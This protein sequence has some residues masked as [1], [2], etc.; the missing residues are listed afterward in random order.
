[1]YS[2]TKINRAEAEDIEHLGAKRKYW[3]T[4]DGE[5]FLFKAEERGTGEDWAEKVV[6]EL[7]RMLGIPHVVYDL[8]L[9]HEGQ[10]ASQPGVICRSFAPR[11]LTLVHGNQLLASQDPGYPAFSGQNYGIREYTVEAVS[12]AIQLLQPPPSPWI[13]SVPQGIN[14]AMAVF[15]GYVMLDAWVANQDRHHQNWAAIQTGSDLRLAPTFDHGA[16]LARNLSDE[17]RKTRLTTRDSGRKVSHFAGRAKSGFYA[18]PTD[19]KTLPAIDAFKKFASQ[20]SNARRLWLEK[21][22][23]IR[24]V[25]IEAIL[26]EIPPSRMTPITRAF[27]LELL[28]INQRRLLA[29]E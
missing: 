27:T 2:I 22:A 18:S 15:I 29:F 4:I 12:N 14:T 24:Q 6:C 21:L 26:S 23:A 16:S 10:M 28:M 17:E 11:P 1:M 3:V 19:Q 8:A 25:D 9:E 20:D 7:A 5:R 13:E